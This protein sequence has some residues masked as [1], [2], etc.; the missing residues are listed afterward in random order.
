MKKYKKRLMASLLCAIVM[1]SNISYVLAVQTTSVTTSSSSPSNSTGNI[2][3]YAQSYIEGLQNKAESSVVSNKKIDSQKL[4]SE[5]QAL[6]DANNK[7]QLEESLK[8]LSNDGKDAYTIAKNKYMTKD[9]LNAF[10]WNLIISQFTV[11]YRNSL[12]DTLSETSFKDMSSKGLVIE[13]NPYLKAY[14]NAVGKSEDDVVNDSRIQDA[15]ASFN[16]SVSEKYDLAKIIDTLKEDNEVSYSPVYT[17][18]GTQ[19][20]ISDLFNVNSLYIHDKITYFGSDIE[21]SDSIWKTM[22]NFNDTYSDLTLTEAM[23]KIQS[24]NTVKDINVPVW[25]QTDGVTAYNLL[26][27][28]DAVRVGGYGTYDNFISDLGDSQLVVDRWGNICSNVNIDGTMKYVIV[29]PAYANP[30]YTSQSLNDEDYAGVGYGMSYTNSGSNKISNIFAESSNSGDK[31]KILYPINNTVSVGGAISRINGGVTATTGTTL[32]DSTVVPSDAYLGASDKIKS[33]YKSE[34]TDM[35]NV[36]VSLNKYS[37]TDNVSN[38]L[39]GTFP[40]ILRVDTTN[41]MMFNKTILANYSRDTANQWSDASNYFYSCLTDRISSYTS[42]T[43]LDSYRSGSA[44]TFANSIIFDKYNVHGVTANSGNL[45]RSVTSAYENVS[46]AVY[47]REDNFDFGTNNNNSGRYKYPVLLNTDKKDSYYGSSSGDMYAKYD[48][49][50]VD[51]N[52]NV[53]KNNGNSCNSDSVYVRYSYNGLKNNKKYVM[54]PSM[55]NNSYRKGIYAPNSL[56]HL[57]GV[58]ASILGIDLFTINGKGFSQTFSEEN[59]IASEKT[60]ILRYFPTESLWNLLYT[61][62]DNYKIYI[63]Y[64]YS[65]EVLPS[66]SNAKYTLSAKE[67]KNSDITYCD[68][69]FEKYCSVPLMDNTI[70]MADDWGI[71]GDNTYSSD[72]VLNDTDNKS[73]QFSD[74]EGFWDPTP[75]VTNG[76][77]GTKKNNQPKSFKSLR[78]FLK[79][80]RVSDVL[81]KYPLSDI[82]L[83]AFTWLNYYIPK[84]SVCSCLDTDISSVDIKTGDSLESD[85]AHAILEKEESKKEETKKTTTTASSKLISEDAILTSYNMLKE[86][87]NL[88]LVYTCENDIYNGDYVYSQ[89]SIASSGEFTSMRYSSQASIV[90]INIPTLLLAV[91]KN[92]SGDNLKYLRNQ[93]DVIEVNTDELLDKVSAFLDHPATSLYN[94]GIGILQKIHSAVAMGTIGRIYDVSWITSFIA[95][96]NYTYYYAMALGIM[97]ALALVVQGIRYVVKKGSSV[98]GFAIQFYKSILYGLVP[99]IILYVLN[100]SLCLISQYMTQETAEKMALVDIEQEVKSSESLNLNF[101]TQYEAFREQFS[102]IDD[103]Y[104][105]LAL[106]FITSYDNDGNAVLKSKTVK[107]L[108]DEVSYSSLLANQ[109]VAATLAEAKYSD[110]RELFDNYDEYASGVVPFY[111]NC[112]EFI[113]VNYDKYGES[114]FYYFYDWIKYQ[115]LKYWSSQDED[116]TE[117]FSK[118]AN[119][120][121]SPQIKDGNY[122][123]WSSYIERMYDAEKNLSVKAYGGVPYM[124][125]DLDYTYNDF[126][127]NGK[128]IN[129]NDNLVDLFGL[130]YLFNMTQSYKAPVDGVNYFGK[131]GVQYFPSSGKTDSYLTSVN[132]T[133]WGDRTCKIFEDNFKNYNSYIS[134]ENTL[135]RNI[136]DLFNPIS[137]IITGPV[138]E[139]Y[140]TSSKIKVGDNDTYSSYAFTPDY[141]ILND[142][143]NLYNCEPYKSSTHKGYKE[144]CNDIKRYGS[145]QADNESFIASTSGSFDPSICRG[146]LSWTVRNWT[147]ML[148]TGLL[149]DADMEF[150][151]VNKTPGNTRAP[152]RVYASKNALYRHTYNAS[153]GTFSNTD[154]SALE[155]TLI[156]LNSKMYDKAV[157]LSSFMSGDMRDSTL[158]FAIALACTFEFNEEFSGSDVAQPASLSLDT[159]DMDKLMRISFSTNIDQIVK[160]HNVIYM[161]CDMKGGILVALPVVIGEVCLCIALIFRFVLIALLLLSAFI[162]CFTH[163]F[164]DDKSKKSLFI[165]L[166]T[167]CISIILSQVLTIG[168]SVILFT[169]LGLNNGWFTNIVKALLIMLCYY[170][171]MRLNLYMLTALARNCKEFGGEVI[172]KSVSALNNSISNLTSKTGYA[173]ANNIN[174]NFNNNLSSREENLKRDNI[175]MV[176]N[177]NRLGNGK[178]KRNFNDTDVSDKKTKPKSYYLNS[179]EIRNIDTLNKKRI[180]KL[181]HYKFDKVVSSTDINKLDKGMR[182]LYLIKTAANTVYR[183]KNK[184]QKNRA[185]VEFMQYMDGKD[186][187]L[188]KAK[189]LRFDKMADAIQNSRGSLDKR[190]KQVS[191]YLYR[192]DIKK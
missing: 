105:K 73:Y 41:N 15:L 170:F 119:K 138:W 152:L 66:N 102:N 166:F 97:V 83:L 181:K 24:S 136:E 84:S 114:V 88:R 179:K 132:L 8:L 3:S 76:V 53:T 28:A 116:Y 26:F 122:E 67:K 184:A 180:H 2:F 141:L 109:N 146:S 113:P 171:I 78:Y 82:T 145:I 49:F 34:V 38:G 107:E 42:L 139:K 47:Y 70:D 186:M 118:V 150:Y 172:V 153:T 101:E 144:T 98:K 14:A 74:S 10:K 142:V 185:V 108:Y 143:G 63:S 71:W 36:S 157:E 62:S 44:S 91:N 177:L 20:K 95:N 182:D 135:H 131:V 161:L 75:I 130:S 48:G 106:N 148:G 162:V 90:Q 52:G 129:Q 11:P 64:N 140:C 56:S 60:D 100:N 31:G 72:R 4:S 128:K 13:S 125:N 19:A 80:Q 176:H 51:G 50:S 30:L 178:T 167:Q 45:T 46:D 77:T 163:M 79:D 164:T 9:E 55:V 110:R 23:E 124:Y 40:Y 69:N 189:R 104:T 165:G 35:N 61:D 1:Q 39:V 151:R 27:V 158:I 6:V 54:L 17:D 187:K 103:D 117:T 115:Y 33:V 123:L 120:F 156:N 5:A 68:S 169:S 7:A 22:N 25:I 134:M 29:Y 137:F 188:S 89:Q 65:A 112:D 37:R 18:A 96:S 183:N 147:S 85:T 126:I 43:S 154:T 58:T 191:E 121:T 16:T 155:D 81:E 94:I 174:V 92:T 127:V 192:W 12:Q 173:S 175:K 111:Y 160:E 59:C 133:T 57:E 149:Y 87:N 21:D 93:T 86:N 190:A 168:S 32:S 99:I 159:M